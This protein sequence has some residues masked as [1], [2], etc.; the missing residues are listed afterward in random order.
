MIVRP[1][2]NKYYKKNFNFPIITSHQ[3]IDEYIKTQLYFEKS[4]KINLQMNDVN[5]QVMKSKIYDQLNEQSIIN[6]I[7]YLFD[8][9][10]TGIYVK[11]ENNQLV[12]FIT[13]YNSNFT[14][15]FSEIIKFKEGNVHGYIN[16]KRKYY[17]NRV[18]E[19]NRDVSKWASTNCLL[20][21]EKSDDGP[22]ERYL[23][24]MYDMINKTC[25][26]RKVG[27][28][29]FFITRKD[30]PNIKHDNT[31]P[32][33]HI[34]NSENKKMKPPFNNAKFIPIF[35]QSTTDIH[36]NLLIPTG[37][38]W[39]I[40]TQQFDD[41]KFD[42][43]FKLPSWEERKN[44]VI[45]RG[46]S[47][48]CGNDLNTNPRLKVS[49]ITRELKN[50]NI[51]Y[52]DAG[53]IKI[54]KRDKKIFGNKYVEFQKDIY[55]FHYDFLDKFEQ[56]KYKFTLNIEGNSA[57]YRYGSLFNLGFC[58]LNVESKYKL[59]FEQWL[60]PYEHYI[61]IKH[62]LSDLVE[63]I[64]WC[65]SNDVKCKTISENANKFYKK[66][67][68]RDFIYD[69]LCNSINLIANNYQQLSKYEN[70]SG[71]KKI[72]NSI[73]KNYEFTCKINKMDV[74]HMDNNINDT[75]I[76]VPYNKNIHTENQLQKF[77]NHYDKFN[78]LLVEQTNNTNNFNKGALFNTGF[79]HSYLNYKYFIFHDINL[80]IPRDIIMQTYFSDNLNGVLH[81]GNMENT[82]IKIDNES[83]KKCNG[84]PNTFWNSNDIN[85][86]L[87]LRCCKK[88]INQYKPNVSETLFNENNNLDIQLSHIEK[89][90]FDNINNELDGVLQ[91]CYKI[92]NTITE[93]KLK[94]I[95]VDII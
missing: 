26:N 56:T 82:I 40:I 50:K 71:L 15:D 16:A 67:F 12:Q 52:L 3:E 76:I 25:Q 77:K 10:R 80:I 89:C 74:K 65:L 8:K 20:R 33:E 1:T 90:I 2:Y 85:V 42:P 43:K 81:I 38:D 68:N 34:W 95:S 31:E 75:L 48:G 17:K 69:Y 39:D 60:I 49:M 83:Y 35:S 22:T 37:D 79:K 45:W 86:I 73:Y 32:D 36:A 63:K 78:V 23:D 88:N 87:Y 94:M 92:N 41:Y 91:C 21:T 11:I 13:L 55:N 28:C 70:Q 4:P 58:I 66:Y 57:A 30:F 46:L 18:V 93:N 47:T 61:P 59:W 51:N 53:I 9:F 6:T 72:Y 84:Y 19:M 5:V 54:T 62:D 29:I 24:E 27:N 44:I 7:N 64:E 14:N